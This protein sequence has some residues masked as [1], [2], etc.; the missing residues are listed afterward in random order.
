M[1]V[2]QAVY[3]PMRP[4]S[5]ACQQINNL[6]TPPPTTLQCPPNVPVQD[7]TGVY[8]GCH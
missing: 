2:S 6:D 8:G 7:R 4:N 1:V 3:V 5:R